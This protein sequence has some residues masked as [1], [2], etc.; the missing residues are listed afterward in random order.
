M[1]RRE[2]LK[3]TTNMLAAAAALSPS[4]CAAQLVQ[5]A[6]GPLKVHPQ[7][8]RY[9][10][11]GNSRAI[12]LTGSH[13]WATLQDTGVTPV[14]TFDWQGYLAM[15][16]THNHNF[17]RLWAWQQAAW[18]P[19]TPDKIL[20]EPVL[21]VRAGPGTALDDA[22]KFDLKK[23]NPVYFDR[24]RARVTECR[25]RGIYCAIQLFQGFSSNK[26][27]HCGIQTWSGHPYNVQNNVNSIN[28]D[29][30]GD[31]SVDIDDPAVRELHAAYLK[32][33][34]DTLADLDN[35]LY[36]VI[37]E[38]GGKD[39][40]W[41]VVDTVHKL[42]TE[43]GKR[44]PVGLT[45]AG[46]ERMNEMMASPADWVSPFG[47][48]F[49]YDPPAWDGSKVSV[50][51]T[52]HLWG[53]GGTAA[54]AWKSF[55]RGHNTLLMDAWDP[56]A[57]SPCPEV[58]WGPR[59]GNPLR[60]LN[61]RDDPTWEPVRRALGFTRQYANRMDLASMAPHDDLAST[62]YCLANPE[63][64][65]LVYLPEGDGV[66]VD[67]SRASGVLVSEWMHPTEGTITFGGTVVGGK[68]QSFAVPFVGPAV[69]YIRKERA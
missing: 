58:N 1:H 53:H 43:K 18:A 38:G 45:G 68:K 66:T 19:W 50:N 8:P 3:K 14:P 20:F 22:P 59:P 51:D 13:T 62:S 52:D 67:L 25:D 33:V 17:M 49:L 11:N 10:T 29:K 9:F 60:D 2:F 47:R 37:N 40:D 63:R 24:L 41:W 7:N 54:W 42:E 64:E 12:F 65:F 39:W 56:I 61:R 5:P 35:V 34:V 36:E 6:T 28:G 46:V 32:K 57:G 31:N 44:H 23:F 16:K 30:N 4:Q 48:A 15:M 21:Y 26:G 55:T 69:L 27:H